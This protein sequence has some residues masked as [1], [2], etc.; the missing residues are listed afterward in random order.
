MLSRL[1]LRQAPASFLPLTGYARIV[2]TYFQARPV[3][4]SSLRAAAQTVMAR[5]IVEALQPQPLWNL[6]KQLSEI[7]R[8]SKHEEK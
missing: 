1:T 8:P 7:P 2:K 3:C 4:A 5:G 6:F